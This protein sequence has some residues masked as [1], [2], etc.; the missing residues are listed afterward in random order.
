MSC[1]SPIQ[2]GSKQP[3]PVAAEKV[4]TSFSKRKLFNI[5]L[6]YLSKLSIIIFCLILVLVYDGHRHVAVV[7]IKELFPGT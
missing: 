3:S 4:L 1:A 5:I 2:I 6:S 7:F